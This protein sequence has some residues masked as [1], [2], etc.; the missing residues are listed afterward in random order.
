MFDRLDNTIRNIRV[1]IEQHRET[2]EAN[3]AQTCKSLIEPLLDSMGWDT[4]DLNLVRAEYQGQIAGM[5]ARQYVDYALFQDGKPIMVLE[6]KSLNT[7]L[8]NVIVLK[9]L[10]DYFLDL[11]AKVGILTNGTEYRFYSDSRRP[12]RMDE[13]PFLSVDIT[14]MSDRDKDIVLCF[15]KDSFNL[16]DAKRLSEEIRYLDDIRERLEEILANRDASFIGWIM[17]KIYK[18]RS[19][20]EKKNWFTKLV[21][22]ALNDLRATNHAQESK[23]YV[24]SEGP[25]REHYDPVSQPDS[26][27]QMVKE[28]SPPSQSDWKSLADYEVYRETKKPSTIKFPGNVERPI[29]AWKQILI[30]VGKHLI[31]TG[32]LTSSVCPIPTG[33]RAKNY[34][35]NVQPRQ[36]NGAG[37]HSPAPLP[38]GLHLETGFNKKNTVARARYLLN[39]LGQDPS[40]VWLKTG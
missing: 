22:E 33:H 19:N 24:V 4:R 34:L 27:K 2:L 5:K 1:Q 15:A 9:Q 17:G 36:A 39:Y 7:P 21:R 11:D 32:Q 38:K 29:E 16:D 13:E 14:K 18:G 12:N 31:R 35:V 28:F 40:Q 26:S 20:K 30:E 37:F 3:E 10:R 25:P 23:T 8:D 6:A